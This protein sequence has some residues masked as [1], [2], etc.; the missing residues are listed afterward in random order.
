MDGHAIMPQE[1]CGTKPL[2]V[3][4]ERMASEVSPWQ[5]GYRR[6]QPLAVKTR[7]NSASRSASLAQ[8]G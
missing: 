7:R 4:Y 3:S 2:T 6:H 8:R 5:A 1:A